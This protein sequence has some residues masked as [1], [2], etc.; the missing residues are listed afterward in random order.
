METYRLEYNEI[1]K[2]FHA[3]DEFDTNRANTN[4]WVTI[5]KKIS[6]DSIC[7]FFNFVDTLY[8]NKTKLSLKKVFQLYKAFVKIIE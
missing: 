2:Q 1:Q 6:G 4:G 3:A 5:F 8:P 7:I